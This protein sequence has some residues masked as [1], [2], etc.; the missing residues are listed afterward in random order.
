M[1]MRHIL[2]TILNSKYE[3]GSCHLKFKYRTLVL[4]IVGIYICERCLS[5]ELAAPLKKSHFPSAE[6]WRRCFTVLPLEGGDSG[7]LDER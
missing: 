4:G 5:E 3:C 7:G 6:E 1:N 2:R